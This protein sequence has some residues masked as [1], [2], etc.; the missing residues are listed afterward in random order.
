MNW[1]GEAAS[2]GWLLTSLGGWGWWR[3]RARGQL[4][5]HHNSIPIRVSSA[6]ILVLPPP[7][8]PQTRDTSAEPLQPISVGLSSGYW[9]MGVGGD[10]S[11][12]YKTSFQPLLPLPLLA[13]FP[14][15][16]AE[17]PTSHIHTKWR[18]AS[19]IQRL[20]KVLCGYYC[21]QFLESIFLSCV[22]GFSRV[23]FGGRSLYTLLIPSLKKNKKIKLKSLRKLSCYLAFC[24]RC[25]SSTIAQKGGRLASTS[26]APWQ[27][28]QAWRDGPV[29]FF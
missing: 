10:Q 26:T 18:Q 7:P 5:R 8:S 13:T 21:S 23:D 17:P 12:T 11:R 27:E 15:T 14:S 2:P 19:V 20:L 3:V 6:P 28:T 9:E 24:P 22:C 1:H 25:E 16:Q 29:H 4:L